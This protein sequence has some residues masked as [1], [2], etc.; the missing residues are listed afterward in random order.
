MDFLL[1]LWRF[2]RVRK[3]FWLLPILVMMMV[4]PTFNPSYDDDNGCFLGQNEK[5]LSATMTGFPRRITEERTRQRPAIS[6]SCLVLIHS[7][8]CVNPKSSES[9]FG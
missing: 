9:V 4:G 2:M 1:E 5:N 3:K 7:L 8:V 6:R